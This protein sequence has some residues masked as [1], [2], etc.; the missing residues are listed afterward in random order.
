MGN[1]VSV[2]KKASPLCKGKLLDTEECLNLRR[3]SYNRPG[4]CN[5]PCAS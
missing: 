5:Q 4:E 2:E 1:G 3:A